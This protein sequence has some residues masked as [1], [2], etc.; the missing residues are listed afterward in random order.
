ME[1]V[2]EI[3]IEKSIPMPPAG[4]KNGLAKYPWKSMAVGDSF[5]FPAGV[6]HQAAS[7]NITS[8]QKRTGFQFSYRSTSEGIRCW[9][10]A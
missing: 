6:S 9:R 2:T 4:G 3:K 5:L 7:S 1:A 10:V 8:A